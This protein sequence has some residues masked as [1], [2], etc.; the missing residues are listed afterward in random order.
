[1]G[2]LNLKVLL[3]LMGKLIKEKRVILILL[4]NNSFLLFNKQN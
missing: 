3:R 1:M 4:Q 2:V